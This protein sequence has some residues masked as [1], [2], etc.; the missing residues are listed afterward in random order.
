MKG[1]FPACLSNIGLIGGPTFLSQKLILQKT[2][3]YFHQQ[4]KQQM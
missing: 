1:Q 2:Y 3:M 4:E